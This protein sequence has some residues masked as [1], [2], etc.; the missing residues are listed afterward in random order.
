MNAL[1][2][3]FSA[4]PYSLP[5]AEKDALLLEEL[6]RLTE[7]HLARCDAYARALRRVDGVRDARSITGLEQVPYLPARLF[8]RF[9]LRSCAPEETFKTLTSS[10]TSSQEVSR[11]VLDKE[12]ARL[13]SKALVHIVG[14][15]VGPKRLPAIL[16]DPPSVV[17][18]G[19][20][21]NARAAGHQGMLTFAEDVFYALDEEMRPDRAGLAAFLEKHRGKPILVFGF[22]FMI[23]EHFVQPFSALPAN[24]RPSLERAVLL[25]GGGWKQLQNRAVSPQTFRDGLERTF[26]IRRVHNFYGMAEQVGSI[27][28]ECEQGYLHAPHFSEVL[29]R[30]PFD[31]S[32]APDGESG[33][34]QTLSVLPGSYPGHSIL[35]EDVASIRGRDDCACGRKGT[36]FW[37]EGRVPAAEARGCSDTYAQTLLAKEAA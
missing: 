33:V 17:S 6:R 14:S 28:M 22:T 13:Q 32:P 21:F 20:R 9:E 23:W 29:I 5:K 4:A 34:L 24:E 37:V 19:R 3:L 15:F 8:K 2:R 7:S 10:G 26:G 18:G 35:T 16:V 36:Y 30:R 12:T 25:H 27:Y 31:W 1:E 11:I